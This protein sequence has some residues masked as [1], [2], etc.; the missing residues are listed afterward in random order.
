[1]QHKSRKQLKPDCDCIRCRFRRVM[2]LPFGS[3][4]REKILEYLE[5]RQ[6]ARHPYGMVVNSRY[7]ASLR[8]DTDLQILIKS[9]K[10]TQL[11]KQRDC[12]SK[13][14]NVLVLSKYY[15]NFQLK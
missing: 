3:E 1:M 14:V 10:L 12:G 8:Y 15:E 4:R 9:G 13:R 6:D 11:P 2:A 5:T 7:Q